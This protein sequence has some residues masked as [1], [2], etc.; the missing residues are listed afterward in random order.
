MFGA[1]ARIHANTEL[2]CSGAGGQEGQ[3]QRRRACLESVRRG[4]GVG[5][6]YRGEDR[7]ELRNHGVVTGAL[8]LQ[9]AVELSGL[10]EFLA[11]GVDRFRR[12]RICRGVKR[13][14]LQTV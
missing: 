7:L 3:I 4:I 9:R 13:E 11:L 6:L 10:K 14:A 12:G 5:S 1:G 2:A 8:I